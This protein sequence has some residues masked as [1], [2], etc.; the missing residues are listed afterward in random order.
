MERLRELAAELKAAYDMQ[1]TARVLQ[2]EVRAR[3]VAELGQEEAGHFLDML[4]G[5]AG[6][7]TEP[8]PPESPER[9]TG[10][11]RTTP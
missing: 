10:G 8:W 7:W 4:K 6:Y 2:S 11:G 3:I 5:Q 1:S 9:S